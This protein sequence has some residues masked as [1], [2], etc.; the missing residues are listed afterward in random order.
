MSRTVV[1]SGYF[2][3]LHVGHIRLLEDAKAL[4]GPNGRLVVI[5]NND[6]QVKLKG[7]KVFMDEKERLEII[8]SLRCVDVAMLSIDKDRTVKRTLE[9]LNPHSFAKG[10]DSDVSNVPEAEV[11][12]RMG[13]K[14]FLN[15]GGP[16]V[17]SS[18]WLKDECK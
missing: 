14:L 4:A 3:P 11:C 5:V 17:Q 12:D 6:E 8:Q 7:S 16:K 10:G 15:V 1:T 13:I 9:F 18:S 2:N